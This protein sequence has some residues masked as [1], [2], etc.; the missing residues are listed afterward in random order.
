MSTVELKKKVITRIRKSEN[1]G[2]LQ[3]VYHLIG[4]EESDLDVYKLSDFQKQAVVKGKKDIE[5]L[6]TLTDDHANLPAQ[7]GK[8]IEEWLKG[9]SK[10]SKTNF[11]AKHAKKIHAKNAK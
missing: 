8:K 2:L 9:T 3:E 1:S 11:T 5:K 10:N 7:A 6:R 4:L